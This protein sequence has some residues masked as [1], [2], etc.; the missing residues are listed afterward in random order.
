MYLYISTSDGREEYVATNYDAVR[1]KDEL[2][3]LVAST[4]FI[5]L[6]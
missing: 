1:I 4:E 3:S 5:T 2:D 6:E